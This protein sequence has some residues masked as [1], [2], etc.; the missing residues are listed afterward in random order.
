MNELQ[1]QRSNDACLDRGLLVSLRDGEL[2]P[3]ETAQLQD[4]LAYCPDCASDERQIRTASQEIYQLLDNLGPTPL[5]IPEPRLALAA[6]QVTL[7]HR[8]ALS[9]AAL[10]T[11]TSDRLRPLRTGKPRYHT[12]WWVAAAAA[13]LILLL[14][15][16][17]ASVLASQFLALF[18]VKQFQ[19]VSLD[20]QSLRYGLGE[21]LQDFGTVQVSS[22]NLTNVQHPTQTQIVQELN[23]K[24]LLP[25]QLPSGVGQARQL[26]LVDAAN[27]TFTFNASSTR[28]YLARTGQG[29]V[30]I[31]PQLDGATFTIDLSPGVII[32]YG[33]Q[34]QQ[35]AQDTSSTSI[36]QLGCS[37]GKPFYIGEIPSPVIRATGKASLGDLQ[38]FLL[39]L[40][41]LSSDARLLLQNLDLS[42]GMVPLPVLPQFQAQQVTTHGTK[43]IM[44]VDSS[45]SVGV[46]I[47]QTQGIIYVA[48]GETSDKTQLLNSANS[49]H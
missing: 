29:N 21:D 43:G 47:W 42:N 36:I 45:L 6:F 14:L 20:P 9:D 27:T 18:T 12:S 19:T 34:C 24:L 35:Q 49:L 17:N 32:N 5:E 23:F 22:G 37:G 16:P 31:P 11:A 40:P 4:H 41:K 7:R 28:A 3:Q 39:S 1:P 33:N 25:S 8:P 13:V 44:L 48:A 15:L 2:T 26:T 30:S 46:L 38:T 10:A